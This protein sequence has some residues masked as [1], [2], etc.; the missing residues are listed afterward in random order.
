MKKVLF[1]ILATGL[2]ATAM[3]S[4]QS[5]SKEDSKTATDSTEV[6]Q[7]TETKD[8]ASVASTTT[9]SS[10]LNVS[11]EAKV[12][13]PQFTIE[14]LNNSFAKFEPLK[15]EFLAAINSNDAAK[16][17]EVKAKYNA[18]VVEASAF[19]SQLTRAE[20]QIYIEHYTKLVTQWDK[21][22]AKTKK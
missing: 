8:S 17:K 14:E 18:W 12:N 10:P 5:N 11:P 22:A 3:V 20:N 2:I 16:I 19:G 9:E 21:L 13:A 15:Q 4:C 6:V 1:S 7:T